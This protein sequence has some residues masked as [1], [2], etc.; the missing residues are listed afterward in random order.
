M[1]KK[2]K[3]NFFIFILAIV[4][5]ITFQNCGDIKISKMVVDHSS[6]STTKMT[7]EFCSVASL[8]EEIRTQ[9]IFIV[10]MSGSNIRKIVGNTYTA[11]GAT[12]TIGARFKVI[13]DFVS[14][15]CLKNRPNSRFSIIGFSSDIMPGSTSSLCVKDR[16]V[17]ASALGSQLDE[18][19]DIQD[20]ETVPAPAS[21]R[22]TVYDNS[23]SCAAQTIQSDLA[24]MTAAERKNQFYQV[25]FLSDGQ[26]TDAIG[27]DITNY[28]SILSAVKSIFTAGAQAS[29]IV[30]QPILYGAQIL[31][32]ESEAKYNSAVNV[33]KKIAEEGQS[34]EASVDD[35]SK[36]NFCDLFNSGKKTPYVVTSFGAINMTAHLRNDQLLPD[37]D[38]DGILDEDEIKRGFDPQKPRTGL[39]GNEILDGICRFGADQCVSHS[40]CSA[41][42]SMGFTDCEVTELGLSDAIDSD[43]DG[44]PDLVEFLKRTLPTE[45][46]SDHD[47]DGDGDINLKEISKGRDPNAFDRDVDYKKTMDILRQRSDEA[48]ISCPA[49]QERWLISANNIPLVNTL[50]VR[51]TDPVSQKWPV[52]NHR[53]GENIIFVYYIVQQANENGDGN[54][55]VYGNFFKIYQGQELELKNFKKLGDLNGIFTPIQ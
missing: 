33:M 44:I 25:M 48:T 51:A 12:D 40:Q 47:L 3:F 10:D 26:P 29:S 45:P 5:V 35:V 24:A 11:N 14:S 27:N 49:N 21:M 15:A 9:I 36:I 23:F 17:S 50:E 1:S 38:M 55:E 46:D 54:A 30:V 28:N 37:S 18:L 32:Q 34:V 2:T 6:F 52:A 43:K 20:A 22:S 16:L 4:V 19:R 53:A 41:P 13:E 7:G 31:R 39:N 42:N 8:S